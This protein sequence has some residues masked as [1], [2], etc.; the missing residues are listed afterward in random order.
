[1][2]PS[3]NAAI[4]HVT[5]CHFSRTSWA[6]GHA[7]SIDSAFVTSTQWRL[8]RFWSQEK[9][10][11][12]CTINDILKIKFVQR[13][14][15]YRPIAVCMNEIFTSNCT[16]RLVKKGIC[17]GVN[18]KENCLLFSSFC[19]IQSLIEYSKVESFWYSSIWKVELVLVR[20]Q[21]STTFIH[22]W[23]HLS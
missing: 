7:S 10:C 8:D 9:H 22:N 18:R 19:F 17:S 16:T 3:S 5:S 21:V 20:F 2:E 6:D 11:V 23:F 12:F 13:V 4:Y 15:G 14:I 1:M